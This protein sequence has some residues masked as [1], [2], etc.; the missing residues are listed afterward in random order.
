[1][2]I[3]FIIS[4][5]TAIILIILLFPIFFIISIL[6]KITSNGPVF[7]RQTRMGKNKQPFLIYK[8]RTMAEGAE[9]MQDKYRKYNE[10][11]GPVFKIK[12][13]PRFTKIGK[14]LAYTGFDE[15][16]QLINIIKGDMAFVGPRPLPIAEA[17]KIPKKYHKRFEVLPGITSTW[18]INGTHKLSFREWMELDMNYV[19]NKSL[20][21]DIKIGLQSI[22]MIFR[23]LFL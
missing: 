10:A 18:V 17:N 12:N 4:P 15:L 13:D 14:W 8:F 22:E 19:E 20:F 7:F 11:D 21:M 5:A 23:N 2:T 3:N 6:I 1:M 16:P 9:K